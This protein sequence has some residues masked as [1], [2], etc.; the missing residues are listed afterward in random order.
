M[1]GGMA[2][3]DVELDQGAAGRHT[4]DAYSG[5][6]LLGKVDAGKCSNIRR[7]SFSN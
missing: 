7:M 5:K 6:Q 4:N 3:L 2:F 1:G